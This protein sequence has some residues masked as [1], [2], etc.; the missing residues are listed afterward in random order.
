MFGYRGGDLPR[1]TN[2]DAALRF[3]ENAKTWRGDPADGERKLDG[4][5]RHITIRK[6]AD[7]S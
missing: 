2:Y 4:S 3:Y 7:G 5:K 6:L 1:L